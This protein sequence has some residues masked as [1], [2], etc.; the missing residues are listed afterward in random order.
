[1]EITE[2]RINGFCA[3]TCLCV[4]C[5]LPA[6]GKST[7]AQA[8]NSRA[9]ERGWR[10]TL[11][12]YDDLIPDVAFNVKEVVDD[13]ATSPAQTQWK[14][15]RHVLLQCLEQFLRNPAVLPTLPSSCQINREAWGRLLPVAPVYETSVGSLQADPLPPPLVF[16]LDDNFYYPS[17]RYEV[18][19]LARKYFLGFCQVYVSCPVESCVERNQTR[20][21]PLHRDVILEMSKRMEPP[22]PQRN[23]WERNSVTLDSTDH[24]TEENIQRLMELVSTALEN[25]TSPVQDNTE[26]KE[27]DRQVCVSS[28]VH[29]ADKACRRLVSRSMQAARDNS[30]PSESM[31][32]MAAELNESKTRF[33]QNLRK[34]VLQGLPLNQ[35]GPMD[36]ERMVNRAIDVFDQEKQEITARYLS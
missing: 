21:Q 33:L 2:D 6:A 34:D 1:M 9:V 28:V 35:G 8:F 18:Y 16:L 5:G 10:S 27:A 30:L 12:C 26:L 32:S 31:R 7:F 36:V 20:L 11:I 14:L 15:H 24:I 17:M 3:R 29:Q 22:D 23:P 19:K 13:E 25:P 4:I